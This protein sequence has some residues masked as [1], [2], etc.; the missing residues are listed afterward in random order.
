MSTETRSPRLDALLVRLRAR[1]TRQVLCHGLGTVVAVAAGWLVFAFL[2][3]W[4]LH[5]PGPVRLVHT[6]VLVALP[7]FFLR[8]ELLGRLRRIP[9]RT[10]L[11]L[12][13]ERAHPGLKQLL[14]SAVQLDPSAA[15]DET[16]PLI[17]HV[18][19]DAE[20][21]VENI[22]LDPVID[23]R[24]PRQRLALG[25]LVSL[26]AFAVLSW[27]ASLSS[28]FFQ[29]MLGGDVPW[30]QRT[31]LSVEIPIVGD[32]AQVEATPTE[33][34]VRLARGSDVPVLVRADGA[35]PD[36]VT[37]RFSNGHTA[38][39]SSGG[40]PLFRTV[41][42][43]VH[44]DLEFQAVGG[45]DRDGMP[46]VRLTVLQPPDV[47]GLA[48]RVTPPAY[49]GLP[50]R[51]EY[52]V[53]LEVLQGTE[54]QVF[55]LPDPLEARG[56]VRLLPE[57]RELALEA[58]PFPARPADGEQGDED[59]DA[60]AQEGLSFTFVARESLRYRFELTDASGLPNPDPGLFGVQVYEDRRP[61][62]LLL[63][64]SRAE[65]DIVA[66]GALPLRARVEDDFGLREIRYEVRASQDDDQPLV[67]AALAS[68]EVSHEAGQPAGVSR[69]A[70]ARLE[71][72][73][74]TAGSA[75]SEGSEL[76]MRVTAEDNCAPEANV[77]LSAPVRL[78]IV[79][80]D[81]FLRRLQ[82]QLARASEQ[83]NRLSQLQQKQQRRT[84]EL[85]TAL[86][87]DDMEAGGDSSEVGALLTGQRRV[88]GDSRALARDLAGVAESLL[89]SRVDDRAGP[90][91][92]SLDERLA[93]FSERSFRPEPWRAVAS[94]YADGQLG[95]AGLA[96]QLVNIVGLALSI[97]EDHTASASDSMAAA[98]ESTAPGGVREAVAAAFD[99]QGVAMERIDELLEQLAEWDNYQSIL[100]LTRDLLNGQQNLSERTRQFAQEH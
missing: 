63:S 57:D 78:R 29:R 86:S 49:S 72:D 13:V 11:A 94:A 20:Q 27:N 51:I 76:S 52:D 10:G 5:V 92:E 6:L 83:A 38:V 46:S 30:P 2:A 74:L 39:L 93:S 45:D 54:L 3:D 47:A 69:A 53:D 50:A 16:R 96:G 82:D 99:H 8:R 37:L 56:I 77:T 36:E 17:E 32:R 43:S 88:Q 61:E 26:A 65:V 90:L 19:A 31:Y 87:S 58:A 97:S 91:L 15:D 9:D 4:L 14:V 62:V 55:M 85:L 66:G 42:R 59:P 100:T 40:T 68:V 25:V 75:I 34:H 98:L 80:A 44:E 67:S 24:G 81:D 28:I 21:T 64:P 79:S 23:S 48:L 89:Y 22:D 41:L 7:L 73:D 18:V 12:L 95:S 60:L 71:V 1:L 84:R 33:I 35:I 70:R